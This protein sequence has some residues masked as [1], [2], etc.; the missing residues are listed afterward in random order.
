MQRK[1]PSL[2]LNSAK[3]KRAYVPD[4]HTTTKRGAQCLVARSWVYA[5]TGIALLCSED[6][7]RSVRKSNLSRTP[8]WS[9]TTKIRRT[10]HSLSKKI[11]WCLLHISV[12]MGAWPRTRASKL[13]W[14]PPWLPRRL[15]KL[16]A[17]RLVARAIEKVQSPVTTMKR[18]LRIV[19]AHL[20]DCE[21]ACGQRRRVRHGGHEKAHFES[22]RNTKWRW[23]S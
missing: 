13:K 19:K 4:N 21:G 14:R 18:T 6:A 8:S 17:R 9:I 3:N 11:T 1:R 23:P 22:P 7:E 10:K 16:A 15:V 2:T 12:A 20:G 5:V